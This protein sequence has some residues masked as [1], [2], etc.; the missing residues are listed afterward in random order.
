MTDAPATPTPK[1]KGGMMK[2][3]ILFVVAPGILIGGG[4]GAG[5]Y[6]AGRGGHAGPVEDP[7]RPKLMLKD[8]SEHGK[9]ASGPEPA[10]INPA[11]YQA[12][13]F[14]MEQN[15]TSNLRD[16]DGFLQVGLGVST[17]YDEKVLDNLKR[18]E[19]PVRSAVLE[20]LS[21][22]EAETLNSEQGKAALRK[23]L[24]DAINNVLKQQE[25]F[26]GVD[27]VYFTSFVIQ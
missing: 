3:L 27:N 8:G 11:K 2:K 7:N 13:Y 24:R 26:G 16:T 9:E 25:G 23:S 22:Q 17:F 15:F 18:A 19:M 12:T 21:Q 1:K 4:V 6:A 14:Q 10:T 20:V 5:L